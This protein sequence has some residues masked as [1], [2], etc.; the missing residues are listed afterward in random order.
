MR[1]EFIVDPWYNNYYTN[2][3]TDVRKHDDHTFSI[4]G[5]TP[6][7]RDEMLYEYTF[8]PVARHFHKLDADWVTDYN[9]L[10]PPGTGPY[11]ISRV[12][13]GQYIEFKRN[14][15]WWGDKNKY[16][17]NRYNPDTIRVTVIRDENVA[18]EH[19]VRGE[20]DAFALTIPRFWYEKAQGEVFDKG[21]INKIKFYTDSPQPSQGMWLNMENPILA[22]HN[23]RLGLQHSMNVELMITS[24]LRGDYE[25]LR[26]HYDGYWDYSNPNIEPRKFDLAKATEYFNAA[27]WTTRG[28][29]G[30]RTKDGRRLSFTVTYS[31]GEHTP[32]LVLLR[33]EA[34][35]AGVELNLQLQDSSAAF[36]QILEKKHQIAWMGWSTSLTPQF[37][38]H[39]HS[40][41]AHKTQT[42]NITN[43][44]DPELD[45]L[46]IEYRDATEKDR[47]I[48]LAH[49]IEQRLHDMAQFIPM[50]K[51]PYTREG[52]WRWLKLPDHYATRT[53]DAVL[54]PLSSDLGSDGLFWIDQAAKEETLAARSSG[55]A[56]EP[57]LI[58]DD[59]WH[60]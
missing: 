37:W 40:D 27:G 15:D 2:I 51:V 39:Y 17:A 54:N 35:K 12:E 58:E 53:S 6:K 8:G 46:I 43:T 29:D 28:P 1:S 30:I 24:L 44:D 41:N 16:F 50:Y 59:T 20:I 21:Y 55:R 5:A 38:E 47:R 9:W 11:Q 57:V 48:A 31:T 60:R 56:F 19:F 14:P 34:R 45:K 32:R 18:W 3:V 23:V 10:I 49:E 4:V 33:E 7:P 13:K 26:A 36:K 52:Y 25:R 42:N 22:D